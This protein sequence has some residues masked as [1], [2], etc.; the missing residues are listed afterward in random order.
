MAEPQAISGDAPR[1]AASALAS[2][3]G[4]QRLPERLGVLDAYSVALGHL[5]RAVFALHGPAD[6]ALAVGVTQLVE[7]GA[8]VA[9]PCPHSDTIS[10]LWIIPCDLGRRTAALWWR[11]VDAV[12]P[13]AVG[14]NPHRGFPLA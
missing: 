10:V 14:G 1:A 11:Q 8:A 12:I 9:C 2:V 3:T 13:A 5:A 4:D 7:D 6:E